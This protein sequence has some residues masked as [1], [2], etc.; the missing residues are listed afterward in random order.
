MLQQIVL[1]S[2]VNQHLRHNLPYPLQGYRVSVLS[3]TIIYLDFQK[4]FD[5][6][7]HQRLILKLKSNGMGNSVVNWIEQWL[8]DRRQRVVVDGEVSSWKSVL[9]GVPQGSV[10]GS[11]LFLVYINDLEEGVTGKIFKFAA[12]DTKLFTKTKE[13]GDKKKL[14]DDIDK[15]VKWSENGRCY[16]ILGNVNVY[17]QGREI[18]A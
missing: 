12:D 2:C 17:T 3:I 4:A 5:K 6:V 14:Q 10:L 1:F 16:S 11:I 7:P 8:T 9:S 15:L 13:I 18:L